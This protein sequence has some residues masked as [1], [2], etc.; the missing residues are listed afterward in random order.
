MVYA[1][2]IQNIYPP[3]DFFKSFYND[4]IRKEFTM[5]VSSQFWWFWILLL[6]IFCVLQ[7]CFTPPEFRLQHS[8]YG[9]FAFCCTYYFCRRA[10]V[11]K[12]S[13]LRII[14]F[15]SIFI[16]IL[17]SGGKKFPPKPTG[18]AP[19]AIQSGFIR[20]MRVV[21]ARVS[22]VGREGARLAW[23]STDH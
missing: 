22:L 10:G 7:I 4:G 12:F 18:A 3:F 11:S 5:Y 13:Y 16:S 8:S 15:I 6:I 2:T 21:H 9:K 23:W 1:T 17:E 14:I 20:L 19:S